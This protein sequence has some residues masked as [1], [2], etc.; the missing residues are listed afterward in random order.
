M[1]STPSFP[2]SAIC[3]GP[4]SISPNPTARKR[5]KPSDC[6]R[7]PRSFDVLY[8]LTQFFNLRLD[9][10]SDSGDRKRLALHAG[11]LRKHRVRF[12]M[13]FLQQKVELLAELP[14]AI[15]QFPEL[16]QVAAQ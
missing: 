8:V 13:H 16:L 12:P 4:K 1:T 9:F 6:F 15:Q 10:K 11:R 3:A 5:S 7:V 2:A 14:R